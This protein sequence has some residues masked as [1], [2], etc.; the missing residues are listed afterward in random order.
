MTPQATI[1]IDEWANDWEPSPIIKALTTLLDN[2]DRGEAN[3]AAIPVAMGAGIEA[4]LLR[5]GR[6]FTL[7]ILEQVVR[8]LRQ[9][10]PQFAHYPE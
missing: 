3:P 5:E 4:H 1:T 7:S 6:A 10:H 8:D 2:L 9:N